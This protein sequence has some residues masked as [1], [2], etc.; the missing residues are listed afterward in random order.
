MFVPSE[1]SKNVKLPTI[2]P[3][4]FTRKSTSGGSRATK[5]VISGE[6]RENGHPSNFLPL[7]IPELFHLLIALLI[8]VPRCEYDQN[9]ML[10]IPYH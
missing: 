2:K 7:T 10:I 6:H 3:R 4:R 9:G 5:T 1:R 8:I